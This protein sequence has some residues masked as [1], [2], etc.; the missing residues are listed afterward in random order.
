VQ[1]KSEAQAME[2]GAGLMC[3]HCMHAMQLADELLGQHI[4]WW[5]DPK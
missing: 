5:L 1:H 4:H 3:W 2:G